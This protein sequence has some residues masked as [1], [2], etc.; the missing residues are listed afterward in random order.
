MSISSPVSLLF[1]DQEMV[2]T[3]SVSGFT[4]GE[5]VYIKG[6]FFQNGTSNY[7]GLTNGTDGWVKN[8]AAN[9]SQRAVKIG[10]WDNTMIVKSDFADSG[11]KGEGDYSFKLRYYYGSFTPEWS[12]NTLTVTI[13]EPDPTATS[14]PTSTPTV[15]PTRE[16]TNSPEPTATRVPELPILSPA[17]TP[18]PTIRRIPTPTTPSTFAILEVTAIASEGGVV[19]GSQAGMGEDYT[20]GNKQ[21]AHSW[22]FA[23]LF[24]G[25]GV[26]LLAFALALN[27]TDVWKNLIEQSQKESHSSD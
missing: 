8:S 2:V 19:E 16:P 6:A 21:A 17:Y 26:G 22:V 25:V 3:A 7:F 12:L 1:G 18:K 23:L 10:Q 5:T 27:Q 14:I 9:A 24:V 4:E 13:N 20:G 15:T 11:Y